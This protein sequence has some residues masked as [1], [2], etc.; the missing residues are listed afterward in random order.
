MMVRSR[1]KGGSYIQSDYIAFVDDDNIVYPDMLSEMVQFMN[2]NADVA[3][4][5]PEMYYLDNTKY[6]NYQ[7]INLYTGRTKGFVDQSE[8]QYFKSDGI[9]NV[10]LVRGS[11]FRDHKF[12]ESL[13]QTFTEPDYA[14]MLKKYGWKTIM[15][16][17]AKT[18]HLVDKSE[19]FKER[20]IGFVFS[21]KSYALI[22]N[23]FVLVK[24]YGN[25]HQKIIFFM[26]SI[27]WPVAYTVLAI[28]SGNLKLSK[29][30]WLGYRDGLR[31][32]LF[33]K[34]IWSYK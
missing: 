2:I 14:F 25:F 12:D 27:F 10:F 26:V 31:Y 32:F 20:T 6:L 33:N 8:V 24:R 29:N 3:V 28:R 5:G 15:I 11:V 13:Y 34:L 19:N 16:K 23:R 7:Q 22:R 9:P 30:Y 4:V 17:A 1:N 21:Q 18:L